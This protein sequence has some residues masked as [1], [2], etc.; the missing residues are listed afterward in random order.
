M[1]ERDTDNRRRV[2]VV[3]FN[4]GGPDNLAAVRPFLYN[5]FSDPAIIPLPGGLRQLI[6]G[7]M[8]WRRTPV[9]REIYRSIGG[10]SPILAETEAQ[11][12]ALENK[13]N[14]GGQEGSEFHC[15]TV[16]RYWHP[17]A[18]EVVQQVRDFAADEIVLLPLFPQYSTT[19]TKT[20]LDEWSRIARAAKLSAPTRTVCCYPADEGFIAAHAAAIKK[21]IDEKT[22]GGAFR[23]LLSAHG[24]P[25]K[26]VDRGDPYARQVEQTSDALIKRLLEETGRPDIDYRICYQSRVGPMRWLEPNT[27][28]EIRRA[29]AEGMALI[30]VPIAFV[31]EHSETLA[32]L[33]IEYSRLAAEV[34]VPS[35]NR[36]PALGTDVRF[37]KALSE[38]IMRQLEGGDGESAADEPGKNPCSPGFGACYLNNETKMV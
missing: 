32:E 36:I 14:A 22:G 33:D 2:A 7:I 31:S 5:L 10:G 38:I 30:I 24:L 3:L 26:T 20:S 29:G 15:F 8:A 17:R 13:L 37:I 9:A 11:A 25:Q 16:M 34:G 1:S 21:T 19:T 18:E 4:M 27:A 12:T 23:I 35:Y 6:A 28:D